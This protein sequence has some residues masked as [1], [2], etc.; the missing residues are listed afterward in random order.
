MLFRSYEDFKKDIEVPFEDTTIKVP[1]G[2]DRYLRMDFGDY[3]QLPP[4]DK[5]V[6]RHNADIID[7]NQSYRYYMEEQ[8][9]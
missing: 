8:K 9:K 7:M 6:S 2:Y 4:L 3:M 5:R 1:I